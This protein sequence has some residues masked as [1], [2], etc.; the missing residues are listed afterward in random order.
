VKKQSGEARERPAKAI[1]S[2]GMTLLLASNADRSLMKSVGGWEWVIT[3]TLC[4]GGNCEI[5]K[6]SVFSG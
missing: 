2:W 1:L 4:P 6:K 5:F 3:Q